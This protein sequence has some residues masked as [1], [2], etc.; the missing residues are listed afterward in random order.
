MSYLIRNTDYTNE[1]FVYTSPGYFSDEEI[2][3]IINLSKDL[4]KKEARINGSIKN[5]SIRSS[6]IS[7]ISPN[8][9]SL[10]IFN[11]LSYVVNALNDKFYKYDINTLEDLQYTEYDSHYEGKYA[12]HSDDGYDKNLYRKLSLSV[13]LS[14]SEDYE[15]GDLVFYRHSLHNPTLAPKNK[16]TVILFPSYVLHEV[17]PVT[18]GTRKS[19]VSWVSGPRFK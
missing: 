13:Q 14:D 4:E 17:Q 11:K 7:W 8:D 10:F 6:Y 15:G 5:N 2:D 12:G 18:S 9:D 19:L 16:G 3:Q 1:P